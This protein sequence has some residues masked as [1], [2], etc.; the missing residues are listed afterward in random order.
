MKNSLLALLLLPAVCLATTYVAQWPDRV[1]VEGGVSFNPT[2]EQCRSAG[3]ELE[4][5]RPVVPAVQAPQLSSNEIAQAAAAIVAAQAAAAAAAAQ[6]EADIAAKSNG[7]IQLR[8]NY[9][10]ATTQFCQIAGI[11][12]TNK[13]LAQQVEDAVTAA[14]DT[15]A[16]IML[17]KLAF[18][19]FTQITDLRRMD[20]DDAWERL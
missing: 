19:L 18:K 1:A 14:G 10:S 4:V 16:S 15:P 8:M 12:V 17:L 5:N 9:S 2:P 11:T 7:L 3:Y 13:L 20:G 6:I